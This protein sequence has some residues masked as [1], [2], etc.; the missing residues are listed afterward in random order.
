MITLRRISMT[1][2]GTRSS[3]SPA[4]ADPRTVPEAFERTVA[5]YRTGM[6]LRYKD[7][8]GSF[9]G[10]TYGELEHLA[11]R[12]A[13]ALRGLGIGAGD[14][15]AIISYHGP[16]WVIADLAVLRLGGIVVPIYHTLSPSAMA[17]ILADAGCR[18]VFVENAALRDSIEAV[19][20][21]LAALE[22]I[23]LFEGGAGGGCA[24]PTLDDMLGGIPPDT[25]APAYPKISPEDTA[26]IVYTSGTTGE[27]KGVVLTH[28]NIVSNALAVAR[29]FRVGPD[30]AFLSFLPL[31]HMFEKTCGYYT[32]LFSGVTIA[33]A[34]A[35]TTIVD[36]VKAIRPTLLIIVPRLL[37]KIY[38]AVECEVLESSI[39]RR[40]M[41]RDAV[42]HLNRRVN[43]EY[44][45]EPVPLHLRML[46]AF[47]DRAVAAKFRRIAGD[48]LRLLVS[49]GAALD[50][51][52]A[53]TMLVLGFNVCEGYGLTETSPVVAT[54]TLE[55]NR[56]GTVGKPLEGVEVRIGE[57][58]E[59]LVRGPNVMREYYGKPDDTARAVDAGGW[60]HT[61][62]K[63]RFDEQGNLAITGRLK[64]IIVTSYGKN[65]APAPIESSI[66][67][68]RY[69][70][71]VIVCGEGRKFI[72][73]L[74][75][76]EK[77]AI[78]QFAEERGIVTG[79]YEE[80]LAS[81]EVR[82]LIEREIAE[83]TPDTARFEKVRRFAL[84]AEP[85]TVANKLL[86]PTLKLRRAKVIERYHD[87]IEAMYSEPC[88]E[89]S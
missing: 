85:F 83:A 28:G 82:G 1:D 5:G 17:Y 19:R 31:C 58:D 38:E 16:Q 67:K 73:A 50:R 3:D 81:D 34:G 11:D 18:L 36:D 76:P 42:R 22:H 60:F 4:G 54:A 80:L 26:T 2:T 12:L 71:Q 65:V 55:E 25:A 62:D 35:L 59:I 14:R 49:G 61:G 39:V 56:L 77:C 32:M 89:S 27:P 72:T 70:D 78:E 53:K 68:S 23:V 88:R 37:E 69:I 24:C 86:T 41:V 7:E 29:R 79:G 33:F 15:V 8:S 44:R 64:E 74:V 40:R 21:G 52:L 13:V 46:C 57:Y 43:L 51:R 47:Y 75:V 63:G 87:T 10:I 45:G 48:R 66:A 6:A 84:I 30:D 20:Q 9:T